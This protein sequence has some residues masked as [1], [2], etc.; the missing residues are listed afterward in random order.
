MIMKPSDLPPDFSLDSL[1]AEANRC[2]ACGLCLPHCPTYRVT[3]SE[4]DS[5]RGRIALMSGVAGGRIPMNERFALHIDRCLTCRACE[6][7]C[8]NHVRFGQLI[9]GTRAMMASSSIPLGGSTQA[10]KS[11]FRRWV[12]R[13][14]IGKPARID[15]LR[16]LLRFYQRSGMQKLLR[17]SGLF[18]KTKLILLETQ[19]PRI[20]KPYSLPGRP[21]FAGSWQAVYP[22][23][24]QP[25]GEVGLFLGCVAR[26]TDTATLNATIVVLNQL[27][28]TVHVPP[29]QT[30]C[31][32]LHQ[33]GGDK[34][35]A[36]QLAHRNISAFDGLN[37]EA[38]IST[39]SGC[40]VQLTEYSTLPPSPRS[41]ESAP[42]LEAGNG[43]DG[44][45][46][47]SKRFSAKVMDISAF[48]AV[49]EGWDEIKLAPLTYKISVHEP[50]SLRNVLRGSASSY[51][52]LAR[53][54]GAQIAP[55]TGN[56]QCCG[57]A[58][59]YFLDQ[60][61]MAKVLLHDK[62][63]AISASGA[64]YL[65]TSNVGCA[66]HLASALREAGSEIE[67]LHPVTL[68][69]RQMNITSQI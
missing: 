9:D 38:I 22:T 12:E 30:C 51:A 61:E 5:P 16:P 68:I 55:L 27:G 42:E 17:K 3:Q 62:I 39:A 35:T 13:E 10:S 31:G 6:S 15:A 40:G 45:T 66:M 4:A 60:P 69:A 2:V 29:A 50:C 34:Q 43:C 54:P 7:V 25:R 32:A 11:W 14:I 49:A 37:L 52:L 47:A 44:G 18:G 57:A 48:L 53:I 23:T 65:A 1:I 20:D 56:D 59:T 28:Y 67:V 26:L 8:P 63:T 33:H 21:N 58:G 41:K 24:G 36:A 64:R 19:L 46:P